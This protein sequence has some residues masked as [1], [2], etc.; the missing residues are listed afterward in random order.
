MDNEDY[1]ME[2]TVMLD[3]E[4]VIVLDS[5]TEFL[6][7]NRAQV[8]ETALETIASDLKIASMAFNAQLIQ[9]NASRKN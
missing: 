4:M 5:L 9:V 6:K 7:I 8:L 2:V 1:K 3:P